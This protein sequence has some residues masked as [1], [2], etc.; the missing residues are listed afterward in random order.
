MH[1]INRHEYWKYI[2]GYTGAISRRDNMP[3]LELIAID[4]L[5]FTRFHSL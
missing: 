2:V 3:G 4:K 5:F 1:S